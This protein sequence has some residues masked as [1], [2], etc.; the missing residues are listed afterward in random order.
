MKK[1]LEYKIL[2]FLHKDKTEDFIEISFEKERE[3]SFEVLK[4]TINEL[5]KRDLINTKPPQTTIR[6]EKEKITTYLVYGKLDLCRINLK[7]IE[8][9][10]N[11]ESFDTELKLAES[12]IKANRLNEKNSNFNKLATVVN[13]ILGVIN[14]A[15]LIYQ[16]TKTE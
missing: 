4:Y 5:T 6:N 10:R 3:D 12:N 11:I 1:T 8:Y 9:I 2:K 7:G 14:V 16:A 15:L 13:I